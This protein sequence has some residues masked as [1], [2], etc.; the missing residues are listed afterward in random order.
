VNETERITGWAAEYFRVGGLLADAL[1]DFRTA[2][3]GGRMAAALAA[4]DALHD[5][6]APSETS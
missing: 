3:L 6:L 2:D 4:W 1:R 5:A